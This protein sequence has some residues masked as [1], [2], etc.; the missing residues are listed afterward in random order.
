MPEHVLVTGAGGYIGCIMVEELLARGY[1]VTALDRYFFGIDNLGDSR[2]NERL[3][4]VRKDVRD[5]E[6]ADFEG[7]HAVFDLASLSNDPCGDL[8]PGMTLAINHQGRARV[9]AKAKAAG[10]ARYVLASSCSVYGDGGGELLTETS[11]TTPQTVYARC[12]LLAE[13][14]AFELADESFTASALRNAT[15]FGVAPRMRF[16]LVINIMTLHA[17]ERNKILVLGGGRQWRPLIHVRDVARSFIAVMKAPSEAVNGKAFN[18]GVTNMQVRTVAAVVRE[19]L[20]FPI[21]IE[22]APDDPDKRDY[23]VSFDQ[24]A[25][26][27]GFRAQTTVEEGVKEVYDALKYGTIEPSLRTST[28]RWYRTILEAKQLLDD[29]MLDGRL[30]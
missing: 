15:V 23:R 24:L 9:A 28:V 19:S 14:S 6:A 26:A 12:N 22:I 20:P 7:V 10:V 21:Q 3:H 5:V 27:V 25:Q 30:L 29:V 18:N 8:D 17:Y 11:P 2:A 1:E 13:E 16:D 4:I